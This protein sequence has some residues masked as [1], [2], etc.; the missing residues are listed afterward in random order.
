M[1]TAPRVVLCSGLGDDDSLFDTGGWIG[2]V[3]IYTYVGLTV[4]M[5]REAEVLM[6]LRRCVER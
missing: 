2:K 5:F 4:G 3:K 1:Q 6:A